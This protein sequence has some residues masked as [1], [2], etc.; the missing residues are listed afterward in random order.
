MYELTDTNAVD[1][2]DWVEKDYK[3]KLND[4]LHPET[5]DNIASICQRGYKKF[6]AGVYLIDF[7]LID[8]DLKMI[9]RLLSPNY[10]Y[11]PTEEEEI[12]G[13]Y[14]NQQLRQELEPGD[15]TDKLMERIENT[16]AKYDYKTHFV[17]IAYAAYNF[18]D[19]ILS[20]YNSGIFPLPHLLRPSHITEKQIKK[21]ILNLQPKLITLDTRNPD[22]MGGNLDK[23]LRVIEELK[24]SGKLEANV[25]I[26]DDSDKSA[27]LSVEQSVKTLAIEC[28][29]SRMARIPQYS[30]SR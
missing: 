16:I 23:W 6:G 19:N 5:F 11:R 20:L 15:S 2:P 3:K 26:D 8:R 9:C 28:V 10:N 29:D 14:V 17:V 25:I 27:N 1:T 21:R 13:Y 7:G 18:D 12:L 4:L 30:A 24:K 22:C